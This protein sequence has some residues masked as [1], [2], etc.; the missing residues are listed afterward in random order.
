MESDNTNQPLSDNP[1][2]NMR[3]E[4][5]LLKLKMKAQFGEAFQ[6]SNDSELPP[7][8]ENEFLKN[9]I[10]FEEA[11]QHIKYVK[12]FELLGK[13]AYKESNTLSDKEVSEELE[14]IESIMEE[15]KMALDVLAKYDDRTIYKFITE[16]LFEHET[17]TGEDSLPGMTNHFIY[18]EFHPN[19]KYDIN[20]R[21]EEF[22]ADWFEQKFSEYSWELGSTFVLPDRC[23]LTKQEFLDKIKLV[24]DSYTKFINCKYIIAE[25]SFQLDDETGMGMGRAEGGVKYDAVLENGELVQIEGPFKLYM[26]MEDNWWN[27]IYFVFPGFEW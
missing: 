17:E 6:M 18:E 23:L 1:D 26:S 3:M 20:R 5:E 21:A 14:R 13:P 24:F 4:N 22:L 25:I 8:V 2:E 15:H 27:I 9:V 12:V 11:H 7:E 16:E 10:A 19:H